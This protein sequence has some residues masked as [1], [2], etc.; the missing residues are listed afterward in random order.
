[1]IASQKEP[2]TVK[3]VFASMVSGT[4]LKVT[5]I[6][7]AVEVV[8]LL[9]GTMIPIS[10]ST[11]NQISGQ[12]SNLANTVATMGFAGRA[13]FIFFNNFRL[14]ALEIVPA[15]GWFIFGYSMYNTALAIEVLGIVAH[16]PGPLIAFTLFLQPH[17][18]LELPA[19]AIATTQ[20]FYLVS[21]VVR[22][23]RFRFEAARSGI[24]FLFVGAEL[25]V[26]ALFESLEVS[27]ATSVVT[28]F[29]VPW[30][31]FAVLAGLL[32]IGRRWVLRSYSAEKPA[33]MPFVT[34]SFCIK[35][36]ARVPEGALYC[37]QCGE[38]IYQPV[39]SLL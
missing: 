31:L 23:S 36:G 37:D 24:V 34:A 5:L 15:L 25:I 38:R 9:F 29:V 32:L 11:V 22:R 16:L 33:P 6:V 35:C 14:G 39:K 27:I 3:G 10:Q 20:S 4:W 19:Y 8:F 17:S 13:A 21:T 2:I 28:E 12:N 18:W 30:A 7:F 1:M 26:A